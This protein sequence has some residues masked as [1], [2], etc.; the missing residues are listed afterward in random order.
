MLKSYDGVL[1]IGGH[2]FVAKAISSSPCAYKP[3]AAQTHFTLTS[4]TSNFVWHYAPKGTCWNYAP[5]IF[6]VSKTKILAAPNDQRH[7]S[8]YHLAGT[9]KF[10][11]TLRKRAKRKEE[12]DCLRSF[13]ASAFHRVKT[14]KRCGRARKFEC[15]RK[16]A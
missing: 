14:E 13:L 9:V 12:E 2:F 11:S 1:R 16:S 6:A 10:H 3:C 7:Y 8:K 15:L 4:V 5:A